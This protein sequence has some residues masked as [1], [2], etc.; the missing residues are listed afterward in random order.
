MRFV[1]H[2]CGWLGGLLPWRRSPVCGNQKWVWVGS[3]RAV[4]GPT[5]PPVDGAFITHGPF[6]SV[7][8]SAGGEDLYPPSWVSRSSAPK[9][10]G[11]GRRLLLGG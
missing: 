5:S 8:N 2:G 6:A 1:T 11:G 3:A 4:G 9:H 7:L 10:M